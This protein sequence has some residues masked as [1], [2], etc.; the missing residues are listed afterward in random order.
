MRKKDVT[1]AVAVFKVDGS[2]KGV[3][4]RPA[5]L[6]KGKVSGVLVTSN[7]G[8]PGA[9]AQIRIRG[10]SSLRASNDPLVVIDGVPL[11]NTGVAGMGDPLSALNPN[12]IESMTVLRDASAT[13]V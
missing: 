5:D 6:R 13:D 4:T 7:S 1:G 12:D 9:G 8:A 10:G 11:D 3:T 2:N